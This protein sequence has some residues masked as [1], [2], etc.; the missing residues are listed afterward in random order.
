MEGLWPALITDAAA[1]MALAGALWRS[2]THRLDLAQKSIDQKVDRAFCELRSQSI[3]DDI[4]EIKASQ[5]NMARTLEEIKVSL[6]R[7]NGK[8]RAG[9]DQE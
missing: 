2:N 9:K 5:Q 7:E 3:H 6:A 1:L 4:L 8:R